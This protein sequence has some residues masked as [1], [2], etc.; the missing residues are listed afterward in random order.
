MIAL[1]KP[2]QQHK[3][4]TEKQFAAQIAALEK[5]HPGWVVLAIASATRESRVTVLAP[6]ATPGGVASDTELASITVTS[7][8]RATPEHTRAEVARLARRACQALEWVIAP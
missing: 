5:Q 4:L 7:C 8:S 1:G 2:R 6:R 3:G